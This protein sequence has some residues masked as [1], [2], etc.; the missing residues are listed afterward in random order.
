MSAES[1]TPAPVAPAAH[2]IVFDAAGAWCRGWYH[3]PAGAARGLAVVMCPPI[4]YEAICSYP[5][6]HQLARAF[7]AQGFPVLRF[8]YHG[9]ADSAGDDHE[10]SRVEA[11]RQST[12][13]AVEQVR[14]H[15]GASQIAL[16]G[17][18]VGGTLAIDV[19]ARIGGVDSLL[20]WA[21]CPTGKSFL[22]ELR[23]GGATEEEGHLLAFG[24]PY[25]TQTVK[26]LQ[27][28]DATRP[29][30]RPAKRALVI[31]R[32]DLRVESPL[33]VA[34]RKAGVDTHH[35]TWPGYQAMVGEP[36]EGVLS[37][38]T[39]AL[40]TQWLLHSRAAGTQ[41]ETP[42]PAAAQNSARV[43]GEVQETVLMMGPAG[44]LCGVLA[45]PADGAAPHR[46]GRTGVLLLNVGGNYRIGPH[47]FYVS[48]ARAMAA[49]GYRVLRLDVAGIGDSP[50]VDGQPWANL[51]QRESAADVRAAM[52][53]LAARG[54]R[55]F[56]LMGI[57]SGSY[58][59]FQAA[60]VDTRVDGLVLMN[61]RLLE[62]TPGQPGDT[63]Q[64]SMQQYAKSTAWYRQAL[65]RPETWKRLLA[66]E[67]NVR[68]IAGR[69]LS[70]GAARAQRLLSLDS[71]HEESLQRKMKKLCRRG[72]DVLMLVSDA[73]DG[74]DYVEFHFGP[75]GR[76]V[77]ANNF[78]MAYVPEADH[79]FSRPGNQEY[80]L[81]ELLRHLASRLP[82][83]HG[84]HSSPPERIPA[85][86]EP[87]PAPSPTL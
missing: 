50:P 5:T 1:A 34:L 60:L 51:Y 81:S 45:E 28:L 6:Y 11:W 37:P 14:E 19:A 15:S 25:S 76:R 41:A 62:W 66:G 68:L 43:T 80:V 70:L 69:F 78:R 75:E 30:I 13:A 29:Q 44:A 87:E 46:R 12:V 18:R 83:P 4:G 39:L 20:L 17:L 40:L 49:A 53:A 52:D 57:C 56:V 85:A 26:D 9:T 72:T 31:G 48:A 38:Q 71:E 8:D 2:P 32:D 24:Y 36:R 73:D 7:A 35:D 16:F 65:F 23:A 27:A 54:C 22:R 84:T 55:E 61:S 77:R 86:L 58:L 63:W 74:R 42:A 3:P 33:P 59:A 82:P 10:P 67:V 64:N 47:R 21:P 79:T